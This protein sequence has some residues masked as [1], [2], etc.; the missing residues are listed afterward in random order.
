MRKNINKIETFLIAGVIIAGTLSGCGSGSSS[1]SYK[2][3]EP[4]LAY[5]SDYAAS[6]D[7]YYDEAYDMAEEEAYDE[8]YMSNGSEGVEKVGDETVEKSA[9]KI[10]K[11]VNISAE[12]EEFDDFIANVTR[13]VE[14]LGG[15]MESTN[16]NGRS[17]NSSRANYRNA[18]ITA[19]IPSDKLD[20]FVDHVSSASNITNKS[21]S[22][23]DVTLNYADTEA[24]IKSL[25]TEQARLDELLLKAD[26]I[27]TIIAI[28]RRITDVRYE[29][30]SYESRLRTIDNQ[31][32][33]STVYISV[34][35]VERYT[36]VE[37]VKQT[38]GER[39]IIGFTENLIKVKEFIVDFFVE[40]I[41]AIPVI[42][43]ILVFLAIPAVIIFF[44]IRFIINLANGPEY[45]AKK[46]AEKEAKKAAKKAGKSSPAGNDIAKNSLEQNDNSKADENDV[47]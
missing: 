11:N 36:P 43:L 44:I 41:I 22:A 13:K 32:D 38:V 25:R 4:A 39:I 23:D 40:L 34:S 9:R 45:R 16:I 31:V 14:S 5:E 27:E 7:I 15:Y 6:D 20:D 47:N 28:E 3:S 10:I 19:R 8:S 37:E 35:E 33:Y 21:E 30:E 1:S 29:L 46:K 18:S 24:H 26:D 2:A 42:V 17:I 12:T